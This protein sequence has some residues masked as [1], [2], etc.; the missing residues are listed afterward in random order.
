MRGERVRVVQKSDGRSEGRG[1]RRLGEP[2][3]RVR[4]RDIGNPQTAVRGTRWSE[5]CFDES[6]AGEQRRLTRV[7]PENVKGRIPAFDPY[8]GCL[9]GRTQ[10][11]RDD[12]RARRGLKGSR[13]MRLEVGDAAGRDGDDQVLGRASAT[14]DRQPAS[15]NES[16]AEALNSL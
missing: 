10:P 4:P 13:E 3:L 14:A 2:G 1:E 5:R 12:V 16:E 15:Q 11:Y 9:I 7:D 6:L 8:P